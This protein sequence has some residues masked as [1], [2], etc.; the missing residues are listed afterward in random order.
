MLG[1]GPA[2]CCI[3]ELFIL[4]SSSSL[5]M[6]RSF[7]VSSFSGVLDLDLFF[8]IFVEFTFA[9]WFARCPLL[10]LLNSRGLAGSSCATG[11][12]TM[13]RSR[14]SRNS[15]G[16]CRAAATACSCCTTGC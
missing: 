4:S 9:R 8:F 2:R 11:C 16:G 3:D 14:S 12:I 15:L 6:V 10:A 1:G 5:A 7:V 13:L